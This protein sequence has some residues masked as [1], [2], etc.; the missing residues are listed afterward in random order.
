[1]QY[2]EDDTKNEKGRDFLGVRSEFLF[3]KGRRM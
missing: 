3:G 1:M 2:E